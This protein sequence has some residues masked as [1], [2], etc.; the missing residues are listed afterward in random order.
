MATSE[1]VVMCAHLLEDP[2]AGRR[3]GSAGSIGPETIVD[4][5]ESRAQSVQRQH[6]S[7]ESRQLRRSKTPRISKNRSR[8]TTN[9]SPGSSREIEKLGFKVTPSV[10]NFVLIHFPRARARPPADADE[11]LTR[12]GIIL[13][14]VAGYGLPNALR[15]TIGTEEANQLVV[16]RAAEIF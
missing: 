10:A 14:R 8:T 5:S 2:W 13:R 11:F 7:D 3:C 1:N 9:G 16:A 6:A 4:A 15:M 12:R